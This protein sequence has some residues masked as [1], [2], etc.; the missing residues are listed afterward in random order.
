MLNKIKP[1]IERVAEYLGV[2][3]IPIEF[4][5][6]VDD[7]RLVLRPEV[8]IVIN[9]KYQDDYF[10]CAKAVTHE[11]RHLFQMY[12][13]AIMKDE[14]ARRW[15]A[16]FVDPLTSEN[17]DITSNIA[18]ATR[19]AYQET[20]LDAFAFTKYFLERFEGMKV[21]HPSEAYEKVIEKYVEV[22]RETL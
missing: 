4:D 15:K 19:Y 12:W 2:E 7:S 6:I 17:A 22:N 21:V 14:R 20:E 18:D 3:I 9:S 10:E 1:L 16:A 5:N 8:E 13:V 11:Y